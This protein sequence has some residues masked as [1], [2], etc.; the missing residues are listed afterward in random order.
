MPKHTTRNMDERLY[1]IAKRE[2]DEA[3]KDSR[4]HDS[5]NSIATEVYQSARLEFGLPQQGR[6]LYEE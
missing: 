4:N 2:A 3:L 1:S 5:W 6:K